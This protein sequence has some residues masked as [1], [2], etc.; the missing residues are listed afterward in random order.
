MDSST[1]GRAGAITNSSPGAGR[2][3]APPPPHPR[4][5]PPRHVTR[6][7]AAVPRSRHSPGPRREPL[8]PERGPGGRWVAAPRPSARWAREGRNGDRNRNERGAAA[9]GTVGQG[10]VAPRGHVRARAG[11]R[12]RSP[13]GRPP[14][15][16]LLEL[17][18]ERPP[19]P[20]GLRAAPP[21][22]APGGGSVPRAAPGAPS[23]RRREAAPHLGAAA[24]RAAGAAGPGRPR[25]RV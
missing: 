24:G 10:W 3:R 2:S 25:C 14:A 6:G 7:D 8:Q 16:R 9:A 21:R 11:A 5:G 12:G 19:R 4:P 20:P 15:L 1:A 23:W 18:T 17:L 22:A 13:R